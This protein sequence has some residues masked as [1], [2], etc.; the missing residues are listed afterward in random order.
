VI[1]ASELT[2]ELIDELDEFLMSDQVPGDCMQL[3]DLDGFLTGIAVGPDLIMP[4]E[5]MPVIWHGD[6]P[7]FKDM[8]QAERIMGIIMARYNEIIHL[9]DDEPG[10]FEP[11]LYEAPDGRMLA[12]DWAEGFMDAFG[13]RVDA[14]DAL[15]EDE[16]GRLLMGPIMA[17]LHDKDGKPF[18]KGS[19]EELREIREECAQSLPYAIKGIHDFWKARRQPNNLA[20]RP[21]RKKVGRNEPCPCGSGRK[22]K[23]CCGA[24]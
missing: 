14:W 15:F 7:E 5:W 20:N 16:D 9:L 1:G 11:I 17:Q 22:Y 24:N 12:A 3:S 19:L 23:R 21:S 6:Q 8:A 10:A 2:P 4:S 13:L 18:I